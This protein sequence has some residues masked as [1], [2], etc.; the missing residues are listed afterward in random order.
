MT[1]FD[2]LRRAL[3]ANLNDLMDRAMGRGDPL[4]HT[5]GLLEEAA[6]AARA[7]VR[8]A[9]QHL[10]ELERDWRRVRSEAEAAEGAAIA[11]LRAGDEA[12]A[13]EHL[14]RKLEHDAEAREL[15]AVLVRERSYLNELRAAVAALDAKLA[16]ARARA[17]GRQVA[18]ADPVADEWAERIERLEAEADAL[19]E[20][21][22]NRRGRKASPPP[23]EDQLRHLKEKLD[24]KS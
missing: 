13:R 9:A 10:D 4:G 8:E 23:V 21:D 1:P 16:A 14:A 22:R 5:I 20:L 2:R 11:A 17:A 6:M 7:Q 3:R 15:D 18:E 19:G 12:R 24:P